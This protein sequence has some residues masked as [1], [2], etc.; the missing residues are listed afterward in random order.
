MNWYTYLASYQQSHPTCKA[1]RHF[2]VFE[3]EEY[4]FCSYTLYT[5][6]AWRTFPHMTNQPS[7][8]IGLLVILFYLPAYISMV[9]RNSIFNTIPCAM[10]TCQ[11][12]YSTHNI[13]EATRIGKKLT[14]LPRSPPFQTWSELHTAMIGRSRHLDD[15]MT[16][17]V[18]VTHSALVTL[19]GGNRQS[20]E[21]SLH[22]GT[23]LWI[24]ISHVHMSADLCLIGLFAKSC[25]LCY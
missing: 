25:A 3:G 23:A 12:F 6:K 19:C 20:P 9:T 5:F 24:Y 2:V 7:G 11:N 15:V 22:K 21:N 18:H 13:K 8:G 10:Y 1:L 14:N 17:M 4:P 16:C